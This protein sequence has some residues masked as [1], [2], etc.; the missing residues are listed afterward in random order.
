MLPKADPGL[1]PEPALLTHREP[2]LDEAVDAYDS[3]PESREL[4][5]LTADDKRLRR[6]R[7]WRRLR[8]TAY[9]MIALMI[10][11]PIVG[12]FIAYQTVNVPTPKDVADREGQAITLMWGDGKTVMTKIAPVG[13]NRKMVEYK[14][15]PQN[16][17]HAVYAAE[18]STFETNSGFD[19]TGILAAAYNQ[20]TGG[21][22]GGSTITQQYIKKASENEQHTLTRKA[23]EVVKAYKMSKTYDKKDIITAYL[24]TIY[25]GRGAN[26]IQAAAQAYFGVDVGKLTTPQAALL[27]GMIQGPSR[28]GDQ[29]YVAK[30]WNYV[31]NQMVANN[32]L[33]PAERSAAQLPKMIDKSKSKTKALTGDMALVQKRVLQEVEIKLGMTED[34]IQRQGLTIQTTIDRNAQK[35]AEQSVKEVMDGQP[36]NLRPALVAVE[37]NSGAIKAYY[38]GTEDYDYA[39]AIQEPGSSFKPFDLVALLKQGKGLGETYD[40]SDGRKFPGRATPVHNAG[41]NSSCSKDCTVALAMKRSV[42]TVFYDMVLNTT[43]VKPVVQAAQDAGIPKQIP[44]GDANDNGTYNMKAL[45]DEPDGNISIGGGRTRVRTLDM[46]AAYSTFANGGTRR[47]PHLV[48]KV[49]SADGQLMYQA[50]DD[51]TPAFSQDAALNSQIARNVTE[52]LRPIPESSHIPC[53]K[54]HDCAGKTGTQQ[55]QDGNTAANANQNAKAWMVGYTQS[56]STAVSMTAQKNEPIVNAEHKP[57]YGSGLPG[58]I[59]QAFMDKYLKGKNDPAWGLYVPIGKGASE[60]SDSTF[61]STQSST[62]QTQSDT[63]TTTTTRK[64]GGGGGHPGRTTTTTPI[65]PCGFLGCPTTGTTTTNPTQGG[66]GPGHGTPGG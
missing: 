15:I 36:K 24:N 39:W 17:L 23:L 63:T 38:G 26:G 55:F 53:D 31:M 10:I 20:A 47:T 9:A 1:L 42:N 33:T 65:E 40:G 56:I 58:H 66:G 22:G 32:W 45:L 60:A 25:F 59:W 11:G 6:R 48:A 64:H 62:S 27:A 57:I 7:I 35:Y 30:R 41:P 2:A 28:S 52:S 50:N 44:W 4:P 61:T 34:D 13:S 21:V 51:G 54:P 46:A 37:P 16:V 49:F 12:F 14:D 19:I 29:A 8:R 5:A 18:D 43:G 3:G